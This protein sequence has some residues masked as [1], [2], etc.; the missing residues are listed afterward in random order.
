MGYNEKYADGRDVEGGWR[1]GIADTAFDELLYLI[2][3]MQTARNLESV[4]FIL[5]QH[6]DLKIKRAGAAS[7]ATPT[8]EY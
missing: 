1:K 8:L 5:V 2:F 6:S 7:T 3:M 4:V